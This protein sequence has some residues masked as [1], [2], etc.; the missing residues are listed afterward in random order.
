MPIAADIVLFFCHFCYTK[1]P[2][3]NISKY[4]IYDAILFSLLCYIITALL[5]WYNITTLLWWYSCDVILTLNFYVMLFW[6]FLCDVNFCDDIIHPLFDQRNIALSIYCNIS[7]SF[8]RNIACVNRSS[9]EGLTQIWQ[10]WF[11]FTFLTKEFLKIRYN[12]LINDPIYRSCQLNKQV[13]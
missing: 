9:D 7:L 12:F 8:Y 13:S 6:L 2:P 3:P 1:T 4:G 10:T 5:W 11:N